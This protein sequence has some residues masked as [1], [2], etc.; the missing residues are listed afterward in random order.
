MACESHACTLCL[1]RVPSL[2]DTCLRE[3][4]KEMEQGSWRDPV[5]GVGGDCEESFGGL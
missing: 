4:K 5:Q 2:S 3:N 1:A